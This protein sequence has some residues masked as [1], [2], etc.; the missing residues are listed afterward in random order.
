MYVL[1]QRVYVLLLFWKVQP[2]KQKWGVSHWYREGRRAN[3]KMTYRTGHFCNSLLVMMAPHSSAPSQR[4][5]GI[6][7][8]IPLSTLST[9]PLF[10]LVKCS[11]CRA[12]TSELLDCAC[13]S[14][15]EHQAGSWS[16]IEREAG[17]C[18]PD[19][20]QEGKMRG[21]VD[22]ICVETEPT[23][24]QDKRKGRSGAWKASNICFGT[25]LEECI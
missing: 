18:G 20:C 2:R 9:S 11:S 1:R 23:K 14:E 13:M 12:L 8:L 15:H 22:C 7:L 16:N 6:Y 4:T 21:P 17:G 5:K 19:A 25:W 3:T 24:S 10:Q